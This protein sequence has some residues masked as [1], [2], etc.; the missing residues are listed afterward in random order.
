MSDLIPPG[1]YNATIRAYALTETLAHEER[2]KVEFVVSDGEWQGQYVVA[3]YGFKEGAQEKLTFE[4]LR[5]IGW[6]G[7]DLSSVQLDTESVFQITVKHDTNPA[8]GKTKARALVRTGGVEKYALDANRA[9]AFAAKMRQRVAAY[10]AQ[11]GAPASTATPPRTAAPAQTRQTAPATRTAPPATNG[12]PVGSQRNPAP[13][14]A[15][16]W[17]GTG[18]EPGSDDD[19]N[20]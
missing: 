7:V 15:P 11:N 17:D 6:K 8:D 13:A 20:F 1:L 5:A 19:L 3:D 12:R 9:K 10:D 14:G 16:E 18:R 2:F 4:Q